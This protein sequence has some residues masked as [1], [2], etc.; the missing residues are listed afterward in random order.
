MYVTGIGKGCLL[1]RVLLEAVEGTLTDGRAEAA[2]RREEDGPHGT[3]NRSHALYETQDAGRGLFPALAHLHRVLA[4]E[5]LTLVLRHQ[6]DLALG[7]LHDGLDVAD[8]KVAA[9]EAIHVVSAQA[10]AAAARPSR[11]VRVVGL[12][13]RVLLHVLLPDLHRQCRAGVPS[14]PGDVNVQRVPAFRALHRE[15][16]EEVAAAAAAK[17]QTPQCLSAPVRA[18]KYRVHLD[19]CNAALG[20]RLTDVPSLHLYCA[21]PT[22]NFA[23]LWSVQFTHEGVPTS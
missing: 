13:L 23:M 22:S 15:G 11:P 2:A 16:E 10:A 3:T 8:L 21:K 4:G 18:A 5:D 17:R 9:R 7:H 1:R 6:T 14:R 20:I 19:S 12:L